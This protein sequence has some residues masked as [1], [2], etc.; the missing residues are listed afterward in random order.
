[1]TGAENANRLKAL[2]VRYC[3]GRGWLPRV[4]C[5]TTVMH[6]AVVVYRLSKDELAPKEMDVGA[7]GCPEW[8][9]HEDARARHCVRQGFFPAAR[10]GN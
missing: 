8:A 9:Q 4:N 3:R 5:F 10:N 6:E 2:Y 7:P 1:M